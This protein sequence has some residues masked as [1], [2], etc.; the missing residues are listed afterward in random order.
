MPENLKVVFIEDEKIFI[1]AY[2]DMSTEMKLFRFSD[3]EIVHDKAS[4]SE[5][6]DGW[7]NNPG[8]VPSLLFLDLI[9]PK[10]LKYHNK[11]QEEQQKNKTK[12]SLTD[13][14]MDTMGG[15]ELFRKI[16]GY[17]SNMVAKPTRHPEPLTQLPIIILTA[18]Y[19][20]APS[21]R[22]NMLDDEFLLWIDK[23]FIPE[24][25]AGIVDEFMKDSRDKVK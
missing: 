3:P 1:D 10:T 22:A 16:R 12:I 2:Q 15:I 7:I 11:I 23:P 17:D 19:R 25:V 13:N 20:L 21:I 9:L 14:R 8:T 6:I 5:A 18:N 4:A 24:D